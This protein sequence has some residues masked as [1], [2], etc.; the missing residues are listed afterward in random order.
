MLIDV[1][2]MRPGGGPGR[3][4]GATD[5]IPVRGE[6][7]PNAVVVYNGREHRVLSGVRPFIVVDTAG[8]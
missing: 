3:Y 2:M 8:E 7:T 4:I 6:K 1:Y 5:L